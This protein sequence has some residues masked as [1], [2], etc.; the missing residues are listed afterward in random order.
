MSSQIR[1]EERGSAVTLHFRLET[2]AAKVVAFRKA[3]TVQVH[4]TERMDCC[5]GRKKRDEAASNEVTIRMRREP[6]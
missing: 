5:A 3:E 1:S 4:R 6:Q 2:N